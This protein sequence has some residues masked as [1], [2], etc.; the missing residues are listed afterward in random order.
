MESGLLAERGSV[1][2]SQPQTRLADLKN[3]GPHLGD[4]GK[5]RDRGERPDG[6]AGVAPDLVVDR[7]VEPGLSSA[8]GLATAE[9]TPATPLIAPLTTPLATEVTV[10]TPPLATLPTALTTPPIILRAID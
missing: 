9:A 2:P 8:S 1:P 6:H 7:R 4:V 10:L 3:K 5:L